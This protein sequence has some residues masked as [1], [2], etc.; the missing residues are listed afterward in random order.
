MGTAPT[1]IEGRGGIFQIR[2]EQTLLYDKAQ[3][4]RFPEP[5]EV[6]ALL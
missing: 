2:R 1:L 6:L 3:T 4:G 5:G